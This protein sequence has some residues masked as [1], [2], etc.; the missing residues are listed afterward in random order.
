MRH[1]IISEERDIEKLA[2][3]W[4][5]LQ[6]SHGISP[7]TD[8]GWFWSWWSSFGRDHAA[9]HIAT[10]WRQDHLVALI[11]LVILVRNGVRVLE[12]AGSE[13]VDDIDLLSES[14]ATA[15]DLWHFVRK[16]GRFDAAIL[17]DVRPHAPSA[18]I[19]GGFAKASEATRAY[20]LTL[21]G[22]SGAAW[23]DGLS[24]ESRRRLKRKWGKLEKNGAVSFE[25][26]ANEPPPATLLATMIEQKSRWAIARNQPSAFCSPRALAF[27]EQIFA[28]ATDR[29]QAIIT[30]LRCGDEVIASQLYFNFDGKLHFY[31]STYGEAYRAASP[32][33]L[34]LYRTIGWAIDRGLAE[35]DFLRGD[36]AYK[37][38]LASG[39][40]ALQTYSFARTLRG[41]FALAI[42]AYMQQ[43][44]RKRA[45]DRQQ[46]AGGG[47][48]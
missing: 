45:A 47:P 19:L 21:D 46:A 23:F 16:H 38:S 5:R 17:R 32:S 26:Y 18:A 25:V 30:V 15:E 9:L 33:K 35:L 7:F 13:L 3:E 4:Q 1:L 8:F 22:D 37:A 20:F 40:R 27:I 12:W 41:R 31:L 44:R 48:A 28:S 11:P 6:G 36:L 39:Y 42:A 29:E 10:S 2:P 34:L 24:K 43:I 14:R